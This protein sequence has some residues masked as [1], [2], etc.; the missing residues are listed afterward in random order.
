LTAFVAVYVF[1]IVVSVISHVPAGLGVL[2]ATLLLMLPQVPPAHL[3][4][5]VLMYRAIF[6][7]LPLALGVMALALGELQ[8]A[9]RMRISERPQ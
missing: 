3:I 8:G 7:L 6:E 4:G 5:A 2:E 1:G 9:A